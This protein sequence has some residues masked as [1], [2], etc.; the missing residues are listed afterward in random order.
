MIKVNALWRFIEHSSTWINGESHVTSWE[1]DLSDSSKMKS[2]GK[3]TNKVISQQKDLRLISW[4]FSCEY[5][6]FVKKIHQNGCQKYHQRVMQT[7][8]PTKEN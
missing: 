2:G 8:G 7:A 5:N 1:V 3:A 6:Q 4:T